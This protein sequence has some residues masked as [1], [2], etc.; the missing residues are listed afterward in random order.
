VLHR[1]WNRY[2]GARVDSTVPHYEF[3]DPNLW[4]DWNW[5][6]R[7]P[8]SAELRSYFQY[9]AE[10]W[11][12]HKDSIFNTFINSAA[13]QDDEGKWLIKSSDGKAFK[14]QF[15]LPNTGFA[16]KRH[17]PDWDGIDTFKGPWIHPSFWPK[18]EPD[19][20]GKRIAVIGT[21]STGVQL[22]QDLAPVASEFVLFQ[23]TP[24]LALPMKQIQLT[25]QEQTI[26]RDKYKDLFAGRKESFGG[27][28]FNFMGT[29]TFDHSE[30][31]RAKTYQDLW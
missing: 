9:V 18:Q 6:Q 28:D 29:A 12:L 11:D 21:G 10:K 4:T 15:F 20:R 25:N 2:P 31:E 22:V 13:W 24:N 17:I 8:G 3:S 27:F 5:S 14:A 1:Y 23:R 19:L 26:P 30:E 16:A 7:F